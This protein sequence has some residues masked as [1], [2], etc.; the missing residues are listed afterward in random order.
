[1]HACMWSA[2]GGGSERKENEA[3]CLR[4]T[5]APPASSLS[6]SL[7][8]A[9]GVV[10]SS[11]STKVPLSSVGVSQV[12]AFCAESNEPASS[13]DGSSKNRGSSSCSRCKWFEMGLTVSLGK[14]LFRQVRMITLSPRFIVH[15]LL[16]CDLLLRQ[17]GLPNEV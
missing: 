11:W 15:N 13:G 16:P 2:L 14:G 1:M 8:P 6:S 9:Q 12:V 3:V 17:T 10:L 4:S 7:S 5:R